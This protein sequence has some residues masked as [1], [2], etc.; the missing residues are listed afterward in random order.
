M[1]TA[2]AY[3]AL[4]VLCVIVGFALLVGGVVLYFN[5]LAEH[6]QNPFQ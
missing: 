3:A 2:I 6:G 5:W 4:I 1:M